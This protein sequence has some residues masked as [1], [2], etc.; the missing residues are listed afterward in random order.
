[1][2]EADENLWINSVSSGLESSCSFHMLRVMCRTRSG[3][4]T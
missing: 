1:L 2:S 3:R 4:Y